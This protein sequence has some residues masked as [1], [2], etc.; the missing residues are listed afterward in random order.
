MK[1]ALI[2]FAACIVA[3]LVGCVHGADPTGPQPY[4]CMHWQSRTDTVIMG[5]TT[6]TVAA[7][8]CADFGA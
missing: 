3:G 5:D 4:F 7:V 1:R 8:H 6:Q 2:V